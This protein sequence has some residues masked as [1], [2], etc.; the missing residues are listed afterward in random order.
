MSTTV[1]IKI[2]QTFDG[3]NLR[4]YATYN[5]KV[6][7]ITPGMKIDD[8][9]KKFSLTDSVDQNLVNHGLN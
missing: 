2:T 3:I 8:L 9:L 7:H 6:I 4:Y 1:S 5:G